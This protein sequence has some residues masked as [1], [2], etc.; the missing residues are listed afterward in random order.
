MPWRLP[1]RCCSLASLTQ[2]RG[3]HSHYT[4]SKQTCPVQAKPLVPSRT[5]QVQR[6]HVVEL[7]QVWAQ[8]CGTFTPHIVPWHNSHVKPCD[9]HTWNTQ[10][11]PVHASIPAH[12]LQVQSCHVV[13]IRQV[14]AECLEAF[15]PNVVLWHHSYAQPRDHHT[16]NTQA[17]PVHA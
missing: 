4:A 16:N 11:C 15:V 5:L 17:C 10:T 7:R 13:E 6:G 9:R 1:L 2:P 14:W 3:H 8:R 12:T